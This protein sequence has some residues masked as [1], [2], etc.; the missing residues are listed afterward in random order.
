MRPIATV[1]GLG[2]AVVFSSPAAHA[3]TILRLS[4]TGT[5]TAM[6]DELVAQLTANADAATA[7]AAQQQVNQMV[8]AALGDAKG[9]TAVTASTTQYSVWHETD[10]KDIW[11]ASQG[12]ALRS[13]DGG[14]LLTLDR[15]AAAAGPRG[16]GPRLA[17]LPRAVGKD[18]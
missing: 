2:L 17:A 13:H 5:V 12:I 11:H 10:P 16:G 8:E 7:G 3:D 9:L 4:V 15:H 14:G 6:P 18:L 1:I